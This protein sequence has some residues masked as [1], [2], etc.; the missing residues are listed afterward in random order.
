MPDSPTVLSI[1]RDGHW[2]GTSALVNLAGNASD[3]VIVSPVAMHVE[4]L[5]RT[6]PLSGVL[7]GRLRSA[8]PIADLSSAVCT[9]R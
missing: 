4:L 5:Y 2:Q 9:R 3:A 6:R 7:D 8:P 1:P